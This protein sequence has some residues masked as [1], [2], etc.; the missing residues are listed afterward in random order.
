[1]RGK[2]ICVWL[3]VAVLCCHVLSAQQLIADTSLYIRGTVPVIESKLSINNIIIT[4]NRKTKPVIILREISFK[5]GE[6]YDLEELLKKFEQS[7]KQLMNTSLF[8]TVTVAAKNFEGNTVDVII[9]VRERWYIFP[10]PYFKPVDRNLNEWIVAQKASLSRIN[11]G[12]KLLYN[13]FTGHKDNLKFYFFGGY[14]KQVSFSYDKPYIDKKLR[15]GMNVSFAVGKNHEVNYNT[16]N[17]K[18]VFLKDKEDYI[19]NFAMARVEIIYRRAIKTSHRFGIAYTLERVKDTVVA[20]NPLYFKSGRNSIQFPDIYYTMSHYNVDYIPYPTKGYAAEVS[21]GKRGMNNITNLWHLS[22][23]GS[24]SWHLGPKSFINVNSFAAI[25]VPFKQPYFNQH[26][27][28]YGDVFLQGYEY[29]VVD[30][31]A[32]GY[33][34]TSLNKEF[35]NFN[36]RVPARKNKAPERI[37]VRIFGKIFGNAGYVYNPQPG[38]NQLSN[39]MLYSGGVGIDILT[40]YDVTFKLE[41]TFNQLGQNGL[42]LHRK[43]MF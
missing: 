40:F 9:T 1:M 42:F 13:N 10:F 2:K 30:G 27:L 20:L 29:Y 8:H 6:A 22:V 41:W 16:I 23:K 4:G 12:V 7:R 34:K 5:A 21:I 39:T 15:W 26:F 38:D 32:G 35:I 33:L 14:T 43:T 36:I 18:Q 17:D 31:V 11:Y 3:V 28:G 37:P 25:S 24:A 19:R